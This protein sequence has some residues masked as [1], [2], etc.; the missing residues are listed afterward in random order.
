[1]APATVRKHHNILSAALGQAVKWEWIASN[2]AAKARPPSGRTTLT[3]TISS[4]D[5]RRIVEAANTPTEKRPDGDQVLAMAVAFAALTGCRRGELCA[6]R[7]SDV[8][9]SATLTVSRSLTA[10]DKKVTVGAT[11]THQTR[12]MLLDTTALDLLERWRGWQEAQAARA[13]VTLDPD[14]FLLSL[15]PNGSKPLLPAT[16]SHRFHDLM[17]VLGMPYHFHELRHFAATAMIAGGVN[18]RTVATRLGHSTPSLTLSTYAHAVEAADQGAA[19]L[20]GTILGPA[21]S[22]MLGGGAV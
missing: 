2:P 13:E 7:W 16:L 10:L 5:V 17:V 18:V 1:M 8:N 11:K 4:D 22:K 6:L 19:D 20:L 12:R 14:P 9:L 21:A 15:A 3:R